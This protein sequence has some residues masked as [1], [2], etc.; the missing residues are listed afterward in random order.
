M[1]KLL[2]VAIGLLIV[3]SIESCDVIK[4]SV[5]TTADL[6]VGEL[7]GQAVKYVDKNGYLAH[8]ISMKI[9]TFQAEWLGGVEFAPIKEFQFKSGDTAL[10]PGAEEGGK[11]ERKIVTVVLFDPDGNLLIKPYTRELH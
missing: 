5:A 11:K 6:Y 9:P 1:K 7:E 4:Q 2:L 8:F 3:F 10:S